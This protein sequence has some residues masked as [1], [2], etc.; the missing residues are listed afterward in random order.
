MDKNEARK[1]SD[2][3]QK[4]H[5]EKELASLAPI[6]KEAISERVYRTLDQTIKYQTDQGNHDFAKKVIDLKPNI[7]MDK[8]IEHCYP[9]I[10]SSI[11]DA[12]SDLYLEHL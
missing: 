6:M 12:V 8:V 7:D 10:V 5:D 9:W 11:V 4:E 2:Q 1:R 3:I